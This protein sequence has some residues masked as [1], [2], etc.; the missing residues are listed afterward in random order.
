MVLHWNLAPGSTITMPFDVL[1][2]G[3]LSGFRT[4][5]RRIRGANS[6][7]S[8]GCDSPHAPRK[9]VFCHWDEAVKC[10]ATVIFGEAT[11]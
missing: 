6:P 9:L 8:P 5:P 1:A 11:S 4:G 3:R 7:P 2:D 10:M